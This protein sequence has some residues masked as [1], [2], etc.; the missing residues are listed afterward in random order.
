MFTNSLP[1]I[2]QVQAVKKSFRILGFIVPMMLFIGVGLPVYAGSGNTIVENL[3][4]DP[5]Q[6]SVKDPD[7]IRTFQVGQD[8]QTFECDVAPT[9]IFF[10]VEMAMLP[11]ALLIVDCVDYTTEYNLFETFVECVSGP[12]PQDTPISKVGGNILPID[13]TALLLAGAQSTTWMIPVILSGIGIGLFVVSRKSEN[14]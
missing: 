3:G 9:E 13:S 2:I 12:C 6:F 11:I 10:E 4:G 8:L 1:M 7:G 5:V 14:S